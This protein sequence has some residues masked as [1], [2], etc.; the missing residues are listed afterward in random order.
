MDSRTSVTAWRNS[1]SFGF[2]FLTISRASWIRAIGISL[3]Q[4]IYLA[5]KQKD[6]ARC[7]VGTCTTAAQHHGVAPGDTEIASA[8]F[9]SFSLTSEYE[10]SEIL[11]RKDNA[12]AFLRCLRVTRASCK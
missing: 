4:V 11:S 8:C 1:G 3:L 5:G 6:G 2:R 12:S 9:R 10:E 7:R